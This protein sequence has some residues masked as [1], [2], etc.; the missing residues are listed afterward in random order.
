MLVRVP[1]IKA[2]SELGWKPSTNV[3]TA[4]R[5]TVEYYIDQFSEGAQKSA[6]QSDL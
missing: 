2:I 4:I 3:R 6:E 1:S 5:K